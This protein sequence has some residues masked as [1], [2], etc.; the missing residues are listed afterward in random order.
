MSPRTRNCD[1]ATARERL[2]AAESYFQAAG[3]IEEWNDGDDRYRPNSMISNYVLAGIAASDAICSFALG[4]HSQGDDHRAA[5][6]L[7]EKV[8]PG[9]RD[10]SRALGAL[11]ALKTEAGYGARPLTGEQAKKA[12]RSAETLVQAARERVL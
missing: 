11:L 9:G 10:L 2:K 8:T 6:R 1:G 5:I 3:L 7:V 12:R 4:E